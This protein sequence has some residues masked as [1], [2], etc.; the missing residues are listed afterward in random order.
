MSDF[1]HDNY[2]AYAERTLAVDP[3]GFL[4]PFLEVLSPFASLLDVGCGAGRDLLWFK[5]KAF[6]SPAL[7]NLQA[8]PAKTPNAR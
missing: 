6:G 1:Y 2:K 5:K 7:R 8:L 3:A 4:A